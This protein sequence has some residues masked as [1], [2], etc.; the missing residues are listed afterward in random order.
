[1]MKMGIMGEGPKTKLYC[2]VIV[3]LVMPRD[4]KIDFDIDLK[5]TK[6]YNISGIDNLGQSIHIRW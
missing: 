4:S 5:E 1:M 3:A 6:S 2:G